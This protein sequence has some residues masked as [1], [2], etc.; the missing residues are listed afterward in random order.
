[1][2]AASLPAM[3]IAEPLDLDPRAYG[4]EV[5]Q[6]RPVFTMSLVVTPAHLGEVIPH[7]PNTRY[8]EWIDEAA[9]AHSRS[10]GFDGPHFSDRHACF[11][12]RSHELT[13]LGE[14]FEGDRLQLAT[15]VMWFEK[16][17]TERRHLIVRASDD[18]PVFRAT[19]LW[20]Y[21]DLARRKPLRVPEDI[22]ER[23]LT[24]L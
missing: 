20:I 13:Y 14:V 17:R 7:V 23:F 12:V 3:P 4:C 15:W 6:N 16:S 9:I 10:L 11:F 22:V 18:S 19:S 5:P 8:L 2:S 21:V 1:M 24:G